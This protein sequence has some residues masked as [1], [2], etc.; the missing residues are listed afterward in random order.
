VSRI[1]TAT[2]P[3]TRNSAAV[4]RGF[5]AEIAVL[6]PVHGRLSTLNS[7]AARCWELADGRTFSALIDQLLNEFE[8]ERNALERDVRT[9]LDELHQRGLLA[10]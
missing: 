8:V 10:D 4:W 9:F 1:W 6:H 3:I 2:T 7:V 5:E